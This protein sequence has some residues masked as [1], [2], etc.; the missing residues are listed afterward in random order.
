[1]ILVLCQTGQMCNR[2]MT[3][4]G[5]YSLAVKYKEEMCCPIVCDKLRKNFA[6]DESASS[7]KPKIFNIPRLD[8]A[9]WW[10]YYFLRIT[11]LYRV[12]PKKYNN[13]RQHKIQILIDAFAHIDKSAII[14]N[15][16]ACQKYFAFKKETV[17]KCEQMLASYRVKDK[18]LIAVHARRG[19]YRKYRG[20]TF[21]FSD[22]EWLKW[23]IQLNRESSI[24]FVF[25]SNEKIDLVFFQENG[26]DVVQSEGSDVEDLCV[27]SKCDYVI[28]PPSSFSWWA[29]VVGQTPRLEVTRDKRTVTLEEFKIL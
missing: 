2:L 19:D 17:V 14:E 13:K 10:V 21:C 29:M 26:L 22:E 16:E 27:M 6:F 3:L 7:V 23:L 25:F 5:A 12:I 11:R 1:M 9:L 15:L 24:R 28:G 4:I 8:K 18:M 20:G